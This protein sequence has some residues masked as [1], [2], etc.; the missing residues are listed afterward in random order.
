VLIKWWLLAIPHY[1][2]VA[3]L[4]GGLRKGGGLTGLLAI[5][6]ALVLLFTG[7]YPKEI[8]EIVLGFNGWTLRVTAYALLMRDEYPPFR[9]SP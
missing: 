4:S 3:I 7:R 9:L 1:L 6:A 2:I 5:V 8:F